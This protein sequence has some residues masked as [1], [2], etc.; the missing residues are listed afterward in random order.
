MSIRPGSTV[1]KDPNASLVY[2]FNWADW[3]VGA[4]TISTSTFTITGPDAALTKDN[5]TIPTGS[6]TAQVRLLG[7]TL[8]KTYTLTC[9][10]VTNESPAQTEDASIRVT[11]RSK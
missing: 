9:R 3:L 10:V 7:G 2:T 1:T 4:A 8:G 5:E 11:I 6:T